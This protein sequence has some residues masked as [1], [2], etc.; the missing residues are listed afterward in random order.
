[1][2]GNYFSCVSGILYIPPFDSTTA[3]ERK[4]TVTSYSE[5]VMLFVLRLMMQSVR[6]VV[7]K[8]SPFASSYIVTAL[9]IGKKIRR[10]RFDVI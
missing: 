6:F 9:C 3:F 4:V 1:M 5:K 10:L 8:I 7:V 2:L